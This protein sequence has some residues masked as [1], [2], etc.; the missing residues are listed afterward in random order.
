MTPKQQRFVE[1]YTGE[2]NGNATDSYKRA[3]YVCKTDRVAEASAHKLLRNPEVA[4]SIRAATAEVRRAAIATREERQELLTRILRGEETE[5]RLGSGGGEIGSIPFDVPVS[6]KDRLKALEL[7]G[8]MQGDF[9]QRVEHSGP[10]GGPIDIGGGSFD[11]LLSAAKK[12]AGG[13]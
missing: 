5:V 2:C 8:K 10:D 3:G 11:E 6:A 9:V 1:L 7:L 12:R 4:R 13:E